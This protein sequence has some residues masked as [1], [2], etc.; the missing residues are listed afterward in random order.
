MSTPYLSKVPFEQFP[1]L[2]WLSNLTAPAAAIVGDSFKDS[3]LKLFSGLHDSLA[4]MLNSLL[5]KSEKKGERPKSLDSYLITLISDPPESLISYTEAFNDEAFCRWRLA[6]PNP[7]G[8]KLCTSQDLEKFSALKPEH[9][10]QAK[11]DAALARKQLFVCDYSRFANMTPSVETKFALG[12]M[13]LFEIPEDKT[14][15]ERQWISVLAIEVMTKDGTAEIFY[16]SDTIRW[17]I[18]KTIFQSLDGTYHE[19]VLH[20]GQAHLVLESFVV[21]TYRQLPLEHPLFVLL[22]PHMEGTLFINEVADKT[23]VL[24]GGTFE[25]MMSQTYTDIND[26]VASSTYEILREDMSFPAQLKKRGM[27]TES[28][29]AEYPYRDDGMLIWNCIETWVKSYLALYYYNDTDVASDNELQLWIKELRNGGRVQWLKSFDNTVSMLVKVV[30]TVIFNASAQHAAIH[31]PQSPYEEYNPAFPLALANTLPIPQIPTEKDF[32][33]YLPPLDIAT[34]QAQVAYFFTK[35]KYTTLGQYR[36]GHFTD[37]K[38]K[39]PLEQFLLLLERADGRIAERN[40][41]RVGR[42]KAT[43]NETIAENWAYTMMIP[44]RIPQSINI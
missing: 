24:P 30:T 22:A 28:F 37:E 15:R 31:Y 41:R 2:E 8:L 40:R 5:I 18:G 36:K 21:A 9:E 17:K 33:S 43:P 10:N 20:L 42:W 44:S 29:K 23:L 16:P 12:A 39:K 38:L 3:I 1:T 32:L 34:T 25:V 35:V 11:I 6:G 4:N 19:A 13:A 7:C 27:D 14:V 26:L